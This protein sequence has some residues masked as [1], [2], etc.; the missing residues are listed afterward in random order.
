MNKKK[1]IAFFNAFYIPHLGGVEKYTNKIVEELKKD[2]N[3]IIVTTNDNNHLSYEK[4]DN[5]KIYRLPS[6]SFLKNRYPILKIGKEKEYLIRDIYN[7]NIDYVICNTRYYQTSFLGC[8]LSQKKSIPILVI[9]HSSNYINIGIPIVDFF[10]K[11]YENFLTYKIKKFNPR[12]YGVSYRCN[13]WLK[14]FNITA[15]GVFY[16]SIDQND[17]AK[18]NSTNNTQKSTIRFSYIGRIIKEKGIVNLLEAFLLLSKKHD[19]IELLIAGDG[20]ILEEIKEKYKK[21]NIYFLGNINHE[22]VM[23]L[24]NQTDIFV[25]PSM[26]PEG[27]PTSIL[28]AGLM[29]CAIIATDRGGTKEVIA[30]DELGLIVKENVED[31]VNK[32]EYLINNPKQINQLKENIHNQII[33]NFTWQITAS[34]IKEEIEKL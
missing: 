24:C 9:D 11:Y 4:I 1:T 34:K 27:L 28:E 31:L 18:Y 33:N 5:I 29:K 30:N 13:Q 21:D 19:N 15:S 20:P 26:Y 7:Q 10:E 12:F 6:Y 17:Y 8:K 14:H 32:M 22:K 3:I 16:N 25:H 2:F 23:K